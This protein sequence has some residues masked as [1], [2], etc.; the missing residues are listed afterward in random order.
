MTYLVFK[1]F[2]SAYV[3]NAIISQNM[4]LSG[5]VTVQWDQVR[6]TTDGKFVLTKPIDDRHMNYVSEYTE[7][8]DVNL[9]GDN[10]E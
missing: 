7:T 3:V 6:E 4:R 2:P 1:D 5:D 9:V 8:E 10:E